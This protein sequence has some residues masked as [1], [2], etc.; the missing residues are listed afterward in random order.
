[1]NKIYGIA[2]WVCAAG[3]GSLCVFLSEKCRR[4]KQTAQY[5]AGLS[6]LAMTVA[7]MKIKKDAEKAEQEQA[8]EEMTDDENQYLISLL[9]NI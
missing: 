7:G 4:Y 2:G 1:M 9:E 6:D 8:E 5:V 3:L